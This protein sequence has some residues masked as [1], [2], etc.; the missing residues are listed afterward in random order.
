MRRKIVSQSLTTCN[1]IGDGDGFCLNLIN[2][3]G[4][5][6]SLVLSFDQAQSIVMTLPMMLA[7][8]LRAKSGNDNARY[9]FPMGNWTLESTVDSG[10]L[11]ATL[12]TTDGFEA[13]F[14]IPFAACQELGAA[15]QCVGRIGLEE[16]ESQDEATSAAATQLN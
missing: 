4:H 10:C 13:S 16:A 3:A 7:R 2:A 14:G 1:V 8:A 5:E 11:I 15:L 9:V 6:V 12:T